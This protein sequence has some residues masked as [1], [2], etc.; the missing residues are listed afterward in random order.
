MSRPRIITLI[1]SF[2]LALAL[3]YILLQKYI[4]WPAL[5]VYL[6]H[7]ILAVYFLAMLVSNQQYKEDFMAKGE[8][9]L[10]A[11]FF[12][13]ALFLQLAYAPLARYSFGYLIGEKFFLSDVLALFLFLLFAFLFLVSIFV[14]NSFARQGFLS[15]WNTFNNPT[16]YF[17][18]RNLFFPALLFVGYLY[19]QLPFL[20]ITV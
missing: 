17:V 13:Y 16:T 11:I 8:R 15:N 20:I 5:L 1:F 19:F 2:F 4:F 12:S 6:F 10:S 3:G 7:I 18:L 14:F 9:V